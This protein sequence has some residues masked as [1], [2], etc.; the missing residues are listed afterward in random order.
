[1]GAR[2]CVSRVRRERPVTEGPEVEDGVDVPLVL[3]A[4]AEGLGTRVRMVRRREVDVSV[5]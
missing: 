4:E 1:M 2:I 3:G 5:K